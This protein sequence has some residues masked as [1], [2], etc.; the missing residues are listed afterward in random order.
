MHK[1]REGRII[2]YGLSELP[3]L[4]LPVQPVFFSAAGVCTISIIPVLTDRAEYHLQDI[5][6]VRLVVDY[7]GHFICSVQ[8]VVEELQTPGP[9]IVVAELDEGDADLMIPCSLSK[10]S[11]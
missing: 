9:S 6:I 10:C 1:C 5:A 11:Q 8:A 2:A 7:V 4:H 3:S